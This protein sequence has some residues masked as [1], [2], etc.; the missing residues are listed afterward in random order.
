MR[1]TMLNTSGY[2]MGPLPAENLAAY[3]STLLAA[4]IE[5]QLRGTI[6][7]TP[8]GLNIMLAGPA[9]GIASIE[10]QITDLVQPSSPILFK[11]S[12][13][14]DYP[15]RKMLVKIKKEAIAFGIPLPQAPA[16]FVAPETLKRWID[17]GRDDQGRPILL[18]DTRND[19][20]I[21]AGTFKNAVDPHI[22]TFRAFPAAIEQLDP[23]I[24]SNKTVITFCTGGIRCEKAAPYLMSHLQMPVYQLEGGILNYFE[25][26][27]DTHWVGSCFVFDD[28]SALDGAQRPTTRERN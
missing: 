9:S 26:C 25:H 20:E 7:V 14:D 28:R 6:L 3:R 15:Y 27:G 11:H 17:N 24:F 22:E 4:C 10:K 21:V 16:P 12:I 13:S 19:Y 1:Y 2:F 5:A 23:S 8:E 18:L